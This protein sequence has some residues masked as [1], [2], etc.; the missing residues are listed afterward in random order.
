MLG[1]NHRSGDWIFWLD[2]LIAIYNNSIFGQV[3]LSF[4]DP[5]VKELDKVFQIIVWFVVGRQHSRN[6]T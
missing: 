1:F 4:I 2:Q 3:L 5:A 6:A